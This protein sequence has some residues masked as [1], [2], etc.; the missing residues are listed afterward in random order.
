MWRY[1]QISVLGVSLRVHEH[2]THSSEGVQIGGVRSVYG[3]L[4][5]WTTVHHEVHDPVG[6]YGVCCLR[7]AIHGSAQVRFGCERYTRPKRAMKS[8]KLPSSCNC[9]LEQLLNPACR[10]CSTV[11]YQYPINSDDGIRFSDAWGRDP[12]YSVATIEHLHSRIMGTVSVDKR[13]TRRQ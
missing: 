13:A 1:V 11:M 2:M 9:T 7:A 10:R 12:M 6:V 4:G 5:S 8:H 3:V